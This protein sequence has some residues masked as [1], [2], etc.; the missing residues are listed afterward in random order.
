MNLKQVFGIA[1]IINITFASANPARAE[2]I[3]GNGLISQAQDTTIGGFAITEYEPEEI[4]SGA[5]KYYYL[6]K[7]KGKD[8]AGEMI[9]RSMRTS[10]TSGVF[11]DVSTD[12]TQGC[13]GRF[14]IKQIGSRKFNVTW[15]IDGKIKNLS[16]PMAGKS[17]TLQNMT[18]GSFT[19][20]LD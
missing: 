5:V 16:C 19:R 18:F 12:K 6:T 13:Y 8:I 17:V 14:E 10:G 20:W 11:T 2:W 7:S 1:A 3:T 9:V 4:E 15:H